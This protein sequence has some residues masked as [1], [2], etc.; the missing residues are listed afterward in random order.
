MN[1]DF[2]VAAH[3]FASAA[4]LL[5]LVP[6]SAHGSS[7]SSSADGSSGEERG[8]GGSQS[9]LPGLPV[10]VGAAPALAGAGGGTAASTSKGPPVHAKEGIELLKTHFEA[11]ARVRQPPHLSLLAC[12]ILVHAHAPDVPQPNTARSLGSGDACGATRPRC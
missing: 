1:T 11:T 9:F 3:E 2:A 4:D 10:A 12:T 6:S 5:Q 8:E 7:G